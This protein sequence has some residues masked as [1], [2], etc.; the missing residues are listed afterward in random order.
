MAWAGLLIAALSLGQVASAPAPTLPS[1]SAQVEP[2]AILQPASFDQVIALPSTED[3]PG[4]PAWTEP[5]VDPELPQRLRSPWGGSAA[6]VSAHG[7]KGFGSTDLGVNRTWT[8]SPEVNPIFLTTGLGAHL[9]SGPNTLD[10]PG[11]VFDAYMDLSYR[12]LDREWGGI[13]VGVTPGI[14]GDFEN[15]GEKSF[16]VTGRVMADY[17]LSPELTL[18]GGIAVVRQLR[19]HWLPVGGLIWTPNEDWQLDLTIPR[20]RIARRLHQTEEMDLWGYVAG[21]FG[22]GSWS[23][24]DEFGDNVLLSYSD[25]RLLGGVNLWRSSGR[26]LSAEFGYVFSRNI[27]VSEVAVLNPND[28]WVAQLVWVY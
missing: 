27:Y 26:E 22:G 24:R 18:V 28:T 9:F 1:Y 8:W 15:L 2:L 14:Y 25:L 21:Q 3:L 4:T 11:H 17:S 12:A 7:N 13:S 19:S 6:F 23:V 10:L 16:Q 20:P 5:S